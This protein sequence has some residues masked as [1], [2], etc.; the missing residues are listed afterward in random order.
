MRPSRV[1]GLPIAASFPIPMRGNEPKELEAPR[2]DIDQEAVNLPAGDG[3]EVLGD[4]PD[5]PVVPKRCR[6]DPAPQ[7]A[8]ELPEAPLGSLRL[9]PV[10]V[11]DRSATQ[12]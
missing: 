2:R 4:A 9:D 8:R 11:I 7:L 12:S 5:M 6:I 3:L 10:R 1:R